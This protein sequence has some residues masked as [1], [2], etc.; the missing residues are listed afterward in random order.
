[1]A[2]HDAPVLYDPAAGRFDELGGGDVPLGLV[3]DTPYEEFARR[4]LAAGTVLVIR[5]DGVWEAEDPAGKK[6]GKERLREVIRANA[7]R[8]AAEIA[9]ALEKQIGEFLG[10]GQA[11]DDVTFVV[12]RL[13]GA[14]AGGGEQPGPPE[15]NP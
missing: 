12:V 14:D 13:T 11:Q 1:S 8:P 15:R 10:S 3:E 6:F 7:H 4:G 9:Q 2:G 5:T